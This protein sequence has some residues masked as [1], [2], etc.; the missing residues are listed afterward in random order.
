M[1]I[2]KV[3]QYT[4]FKYWKYE[5]HI[6]HKPSAHNLFVIKE[7]YLY[8]IWIHSYFPSP[9]SI[10]CPTCILVFMHDEFSIYSSIMNVQ[11]HVLKSYYMCTVWKKDGNK[12]TECDHR[13]FKTHSILVRWSAFSDFILPV[14]LFDETEVL[15]ET[16]GPFC[17]DRPV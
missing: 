5:C 16:A 2:V 17:I 6:H 3:K 12:D 9:K 11:L 10:D 4:L 13:K 8:S 15:A 1:K 7:Q 14:D